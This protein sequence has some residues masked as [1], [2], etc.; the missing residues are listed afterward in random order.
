[1]PRVRL[2]WRAQTF[3]LPVWHPDGGRARL[4]GNRFKIFGL[5]V[6]LI[7]FVQRGGA[8]AL[9]AIGRA[10]GNQ[11]RRQERKQQQYTHEAPG[12]KPLRSSML[13]V[14]PSCQ[15]FRPFNYIITVP[16]SDAQERGGAPLRCAPSS[17]KMLAVRKCRGSVA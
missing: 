16:I 12:P 10:R 5:F 9:R 1:M 13:G 6:R 11:A 14:A 4:V 15:I 3:Y 8:V 2:S 7:R 17:R